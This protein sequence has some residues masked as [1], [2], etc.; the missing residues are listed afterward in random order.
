MEALRDPEGVEL[1]HLVAACPLPGNRMLEIGCGAGRLTWQYAGLTG[2]V[3][4]I[5]PDAFELRQ[6]KDDRPVSIVNV[7]IL[8]AV[9]EALP[10]SNQTFEVVLF[11]SSF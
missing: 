4:G 7:S 9:C 8:Q 5:D 11:A 1:S 10:F 6:A 3:V 2:Q